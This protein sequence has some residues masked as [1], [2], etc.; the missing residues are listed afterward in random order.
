[1]VEGWAP[2]AT[3]AAWCRAGQA[4]TASGAERWRVAGH[5]VYDA[6]GLVRRQYEPYFS[7]SAADEDDAVLAQCG[8]ATITTYDAAGRVARVDLPNGTYATTT[9]R[10][11]ST[12]SASPGENVGDSLYR[13]RRLVLFASLGDE[14]MAIEFSIRLSRPVESA[15]VV[16]AT[17]E[18][19]RARLAPMS[20]AVASWGSAHLSGDGDELRVTLGGDAGVTACVH[21]VPGA[22]DLG[23][24][25]VERWL[26][27]ASDRTEESLVLT[28]VVAALIAQFVGDLVVDEA[29]LIDGRRLL[30]PGQILEVVAEALRRHGSLRNAALELFA[31]GDAD[32]PPEAHER[33]EH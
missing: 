8:V 22:L 30:H 1:M 19:I 21:L 26:V 29:G 9:V 3:R 7:P 31:L 27:V 23:D 11:W 16:K 14:L 2:R 20:H 17:Q 13:S 4:R 18:W 5:V 10:A 6:K 33:G 15:S 24:G 32:V 28:S 12:V 25:E